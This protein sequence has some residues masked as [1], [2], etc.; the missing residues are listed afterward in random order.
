MRNAATQGQV[1]PEAGSSPWTSTWISTLLRKAAVM[2]AV[3]RTTW[4]IF[5]GWSKARSSMPAVTQTVPQWR[6][7]QM[8]AQMSIHARI[9]PP[10][11]LP[12]ALAWVGSTY[13][14]IAVT[15]R[16]GG[17]GRGSVT[18]TSS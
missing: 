14:V 15:E 1:W 8:A 18:V 5:T 17:R 13:S 11:T 16:E 7:A 2:W 9:W 6:W 10:K 4:P 3:T 12:R